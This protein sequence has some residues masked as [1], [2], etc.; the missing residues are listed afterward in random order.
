MPST[1]VR[2][3]YPRALGDVGL[4]GSPPLSWGETTP[5]A[6]LEGSTRIF[7][8]DVPEGLAVDLKAV[9]ADGRFASGRN[10]TVL[11]G[12]TLLV[13]PHFGEA[14]L[15]DEEPRTIG[16]PGL[17]RPMRFRVFL[18][19]GYAELDARRYPVLYAQDGQSLF[20]ADGWLL[21]ATLNTLWGLGAMEE[22]IIVAVHTDEGR[23]DLLSPTADPGH[24]GGGGPRYR[25][26]LT[27]TL[28]P[29]V[30]TFFRTRRGREDT[31]LIGSSMGGLF[32]FF[33]AWTR[34]DLFGRAASLSGS[35]WWDRRRLV[36]DVA[37]GACPN[38][39]PVLYVDSGAAKDP[40]AED[41]NLRDGYH[42]TMA[43]RRALTGHCYEPGRDLHVLAFPGHAHDAASWAAR[44]AVPLQLLFPPR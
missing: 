22:I 40:L 25:D 18:P 28:K 5:P 15:L 20:G 2:V 23:L 3:R 8:F 37:A 41:A 36:H 6:R 13:E 34:P 10:T 26:F 31:A 38:P 44:L 32:S 19:P 35:F 29:Y 4:R 7:E 17:G 33:A 11:A 39:R 1:V 16:A 12:E 14:G 9:R 42:H 24:G 43:M 27:E 21:D 30:D